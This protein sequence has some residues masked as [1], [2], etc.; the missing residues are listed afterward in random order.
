MTETDP[1]VRALLPQTTPVRLIEADGSPSP[2]S[3]PYRFPETPRLLDGYERMVMARRF[4]IQATALTRQGRLAV[5]PS[6][7]G[8]EA[9]QVGA[10]LALDAADWLFPTYRDS[11][12][13]VARGL[14][15][16]E[17]LAGFRGDWH[18]GYDPPA[19]RVAPQATP[20]AT[21]LV[22]ATGLAHALHL[23][24]QSGVVMALTG[25]GG[26]SEGDFHEALNFAGVLR[27]PVVFVVQNNRWAISVPLAKQTAAPALAYKGV[28]YGVAAEQ[29]DGNDLAAV[30][31]VLGA[32]VDQARSGAGPY[33]VEAHTYRMEA[34]TNAD[35]AARYRDGDEV[36]RWSRADPIVRLEAWL[37]ARGDLDDAG[38]AAVA[39]RAEMLA[40]T[41]RAGAQ[42][43]A[44]GPHDPLRLFDH[45]YAHPT[46]QLVAQR[47][48]LG[49][50][51]QAARLEAAAR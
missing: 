18:C 14:D 24:R 6:S 13:L 49:A 39:D 46:A 45:V 33:L 8:Q 29:V 21:H 16:T 7:R 35:D 47:A 25:D 9:C 11:A 30:L 1:H 41:V 20:L 10:A 22:H 31:A 38:V 5:Y 48:Q 44:A 34:H 4:N 43:D 50:E 15:P 26:T 42:A 28:G 23:R 19:R 3:G 40:A 12:A 32:A 17:V 36:D 37:R 2:R 51:I 27:A